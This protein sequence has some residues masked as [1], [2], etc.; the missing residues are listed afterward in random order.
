MGIR[1]SWSKEN[2]SGGYYYNPGK[3]D[4]DLTGIIEIDIEKSSEILDIF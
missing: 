1:Q 3:D 2:H 4:D